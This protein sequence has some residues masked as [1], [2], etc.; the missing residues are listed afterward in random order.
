MKMI[1]VHKLVKEKQKLQSYAGTVTVN[2]HESYFKCLGQVL[3]TMTF[4]QSM[5]MQ[6]VLH[7]L[8]ECLTCWI[9]KKD[10][11]MKKLSRFLI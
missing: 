2:I 5:H 4:T 1:N 7:N 9:I 6:T 11:L 10:I 8:E 3:S